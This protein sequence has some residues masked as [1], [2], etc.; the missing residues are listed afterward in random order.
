MTREQKKQAVYNAK[1]SVR[2]PKSH[3]LEVL[4]KLYDAGAMADY[5]KLGAIIGR[6]EAWQN[7]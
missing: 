5:K 2:S 3:L 6:L 4:S 7:S 1:H